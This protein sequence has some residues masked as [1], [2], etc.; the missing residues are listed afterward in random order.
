MGALSAS[1]LRCATSECSLHI[2]VGLV[3]GLLDLFDDGHP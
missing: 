1:Q 3:V 2:P